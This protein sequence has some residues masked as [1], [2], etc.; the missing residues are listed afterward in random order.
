MPL[1]LHPTNDN[2]C[3]LYQGQLPNT[4]NTHISTPTTIS[5]RVER[6]LLPFSICLIN[7]TLS[8]RFCNLLNF[9]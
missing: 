5:G 9:Q 8:K 3:I 6:T 7:S 2:T 1:H 4:H